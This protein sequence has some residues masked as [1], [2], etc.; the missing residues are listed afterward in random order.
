VDAKGTADIG[1]AKQLVGDQRQRRENQKSAD[2]G[3][4]TEDR[5][6][7]HH[8]RLRHAGLATARQERLKMRA[9]SIDKQRSDEEEDRGLIAACQT[10]T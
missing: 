2:S 3:Q 5:F 9:I 10:D 7:R 1:K 4:R 8:S 6:L